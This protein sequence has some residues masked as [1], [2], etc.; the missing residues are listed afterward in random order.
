MVQI[1]LSIEM[2]QQFGA[3]IKNAVPGSVELVVIGEDA[4]NGAE[5]FINSEIGKNAVPEQ[6]LAQMPHLRWIHSVYAGLDDIPWELVDARNVIV[7]NSAGVYA[8]MM[9]E[10]VM[11]MLVVMYRNLQGYVFAQKEHR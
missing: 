3:Q 6:F 9:A 1:A 11:A 5:I 4:A 10:Y 8:P 2:L 7:T